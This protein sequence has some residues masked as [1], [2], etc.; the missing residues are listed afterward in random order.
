M[1]VNHTIKFMKKIA[2]MFADGFEEIEA[3][4]TVDILRRAGV[5]CD[6]VSIQK[7]TVTGAHG[8]K[9]Q[10]DKI[11]SEDIKNYD[12]I[13]CPGGL[14][15]AEYLS[16]CEL[17][18]ETIKEF[19]KRTDKYIAAICAS[20]AVVLSKS[21]VVDSKNITCYPTNDFKNMLSNSNY[22]DDNVV[23]DGNIITSRG[24]A[25]ALEFAYKILEVLGYDYNKIM[26][27]ML[28]NK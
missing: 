22:K 17:L 12:M 2:V 25:T 6:I 16:E 26:E 21:G 23:V 27:D 14:P 28:Y 10:S 4:G 20:P 7:E 3:L 8:I 9:I 5:T 24:P 19:D 11:I 18:I 1:I 15:G 13:V